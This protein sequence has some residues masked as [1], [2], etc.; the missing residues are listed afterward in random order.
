M[1]TLLLT[2]SPVAARRCG[3]RLSSNAATLR[4]SNFGCSFLGGAFASL[5]GSA[6]FS[7]LGSAFFC[8]AFFGSGFAKS[9]LI[10]SAIK[11]RCGSDCFF[12]GVGGFGS[13]NGAATSVAAFTSVFATFA[14]GSSAGLRS[15]TLSAIGAAALGAVL[16]PA[17]SWV[18]SLT[19]MTSI[20]IGVESVDRGLAA[21]VSAPHTSTTTCTAIDT[22]KIQASRLLIDMVRPTLIDP[23]LRAP[24]LALL[25][26]RNERDPVEPRARQPSHDPHDG[27]IVDLAIAAHIDALFHAAAGRRDSLQL[28]KDVIDRDLGVLQAPLPLA[29]DRNCERFLVL[30][31]AFGL[32]LWQIEGHTDR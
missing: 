19:V 26:L 1:P 9:F 6:F 24:S 20:G 28:G 14:A 25:N 15:P 11:S 21:K 27:T 3:V 12:S 29:V 10:A 13:G 32:S 23:R 18:N 17:V 16:E 22:P 5:L 31:K 8:S 30:V 2:T 7:G 4:G